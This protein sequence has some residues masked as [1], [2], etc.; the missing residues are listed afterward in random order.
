MMMKDKHG[1]LQARGTGIVRVAPDE[2][3]VHLRVM[4]EA[5]TASEAV[6]TNAKLTQDVIDAV[7]AEPNH[8]VTTTGLSVNPIIRYDS[9]TNTPTIIGFRATNGVEVKTKVG[10]AGQIYDA[11]IKAGANVSSGITFRIQN[12][13]PHREE[14]LRMAAEEAFTQASIVAKT[15]DVELMEPQEIVLNPS[16][17]PVLYRSQALEAKAAATPVMPEELTIS[18]SVQ[19][20]YRTKG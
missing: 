16:S 15:A 11:G 2:A 18:A 19:I 17:G 7:S 9:Q 1:T 8:G 12:E 20:V 4:T 14:A 5:K 10:Y 3:L 6:Q 13:T